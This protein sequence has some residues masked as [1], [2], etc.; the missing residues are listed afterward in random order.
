MSGIVRSSTTRSGSSSRG[1][2]DRLLR[3]LRPAR[4]RRTRSPRAARRAPRGSADGRR[5]SGHA[6]SCP[7]A[8]VPIRRAMRQTAR[9]DA[10]ETFLSGEVALVALLG[11]ALALFLTKSSLRARTICRE[12]RLVLTTLYAVGGGLIALLTAIE[13]HGRG[14]PLRP[15]A[16][17]R[18]LADLGCRGSPSRSALRSSS[19][20]RARPSRGPAS[21]ACSP[22][23]RC[24]RRPPLA[25]GADRAPAAS[26]WST[27]PRPSPCRPGRRSGSSRASA[28][29]R[30]S[31]GSGRSLQH[32][33]SGAP[34]LAALALRRTSSP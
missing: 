16:L 25:R 17:L 7:R 15:A 30:T 33:P 32:Q 4:R 1:E 9:N 21:A 12:L 27:W 2:L 5:R 11:A 13:V 8:I 34:A 3:R 14:P 31:I 24:S 20:P 19:A 23:G 26:R 10:F 29:C 22:A 18:V 28:G 6:R